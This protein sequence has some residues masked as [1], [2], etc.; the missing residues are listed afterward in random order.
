MMANQV[1]SDGQVLDSSALPPP[2]PGLLTAERD[3]LSPQEISLSAYGSRR[4]RLRYPQLTNELAEHRVREKYRKFSE[5]YPVLFSKCCDPAFKLENLHKVLSH[6]ESL[7]AQR[8][9]HEA[10]TDKLIHELNAEYVDPVVTDREAAR[11]YAE[12]VKQQARSPHTH[13]R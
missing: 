9:C 2:P 12:S 5:Q 3:P 13:N 8:T 7:N 1:P 11:L 6:L 4:E 10:A